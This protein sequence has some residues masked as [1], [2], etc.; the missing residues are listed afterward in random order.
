MRYPD[1]LGELR[2][3]LLKALDQSFRG[4]DASTD[5]GVT[6]QRSTWPTRALPSPSAPS[7][8]LAT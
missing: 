5:A 2:H 1:A 6:T 7:I 4:G 8:C 3:V